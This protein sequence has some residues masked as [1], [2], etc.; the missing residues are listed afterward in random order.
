MIVYA[1]GVA[2]RTDE[3]VP[4]KIPVVIANTKPLTTSPPKMRITTSVTNVV[5]DVL[6]V[7]AIVE[8]R[9]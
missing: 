6:N 3:N 2:R 1:R 5:I 9:A 4:M 7:R 8:L